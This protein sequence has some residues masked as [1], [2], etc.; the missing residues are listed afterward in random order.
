MIATTRGIASTM[1]YFETTLAILGDNV[2]FL[3]S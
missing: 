2:M 3:Q 1:A